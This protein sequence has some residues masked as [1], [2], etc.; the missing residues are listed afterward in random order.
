[1][2]PHGS[3]KFDRATPDTASLVERILLNICSK[4]GKLRAVTHIGP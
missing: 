4:G 3:A 1:M 2:T